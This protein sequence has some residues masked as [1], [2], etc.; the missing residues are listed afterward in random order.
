MHSPLVYVDQGCN[1]V[2]NTLTDVYAD[3]L[4]HS[5]VSLI[6]VRNKKCISHSLFQISHSVTGR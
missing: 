6:A 5:I 1:I 2:A 3:I 4:F